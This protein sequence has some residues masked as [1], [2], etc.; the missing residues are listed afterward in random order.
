MCGEAEALACQSRGLPSDQLSVQNAAVILNSPATPLVIDPSSQ[1]SC[2]CQLLLLLFAAQ[3]LAAPRKHSD[4]SAPTHQAELLCLQ[5]LQWLTAQ[6][7]ATLGGPPVEV[8]GAGNARF[9]AVLE[10]AVR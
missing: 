7:Q 5:A 9:A 4:S 6:L 3:G 2:P 1:A 8:V 10:L